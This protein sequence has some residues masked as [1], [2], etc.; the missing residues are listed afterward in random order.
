MPAWLSFDCFSH[1]DGKLD[2]IPS[3]VATVKV[4]GKRKPLDKDTAGEFITYHSIH[5]GDIKFREIIVSDQGF[6]IDNYFEILKV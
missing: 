3:P 2:T 6:S 1:L 5:Y 4:D